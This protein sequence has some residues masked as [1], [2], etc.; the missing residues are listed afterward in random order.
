M[1]VVYFAPTS[2][3]YGDNKA[4]LN[5]LEYIVLKGVDPLIVTT[6]EGP[7]TAKLREKGYAYIIYFPDSNFWPGLH[8]VRDVLL[9]FP[10]LLRHN[11]IRKFK[12]KALYKQL[13]IFKPDIIHSN[14][15][16][17]GI[18]LTI[19]KKLRI[20]H[21]QHIREF[22]KL[23][24]GRLYFPS[25][26]SFVHR[27]STRPNDAVVCV[28]KEIKEYHNKKS[29]TSNWEILYDG[30]LQGDGVL[31]KEKDNYFLY[32]GRLFPGKN[33]IS[34]IL[35]FSKYCQDNHNNGVILK[36]AGD[37]DDYYKQE[38]YKVVNIYNLA[39]RV[40]FLG[41]RADVN[42]LMQKALALFVPSICEGFGFIT[43]E[44][45]FNGCLVV[46]RNSGGT[47]EQFDN[48][49]ELTGQE[50]GLRYDQDSELVPIMEQIV[51]KGQEYYSATIKCARE[52]VVQLYS[53]ENCAKNIYALYKRLC[54]NAI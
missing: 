13:Q 40:E 30:V 45:M 36:I 52:V 47:K 33:V 38:L 1:K 54:N 15:S 9:F 18:G 42:I 41:Y 34:L 51:Q 28:S 26:K 27:I 11:I 12:Y 3:I 6:L 17:F 16:C 10:R 23:D 22:G 2:T 31:N 44:A 48:G 50:I 4:L 35:Q 39:S 25:E 20:P 46:G 8:S 43:V 7:F 32:V 37:G 53:I 14:N 5:L 49:L 19:A 21:V 29:D 24:T